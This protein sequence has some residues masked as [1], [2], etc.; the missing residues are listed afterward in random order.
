MVLLQRSKSSANT[1]DS[2]QIIHARN[3]LDYSILHVA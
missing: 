2:F 1:A 3:I